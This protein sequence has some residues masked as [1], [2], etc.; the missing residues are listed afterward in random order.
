ML[1]SIRVQDPAASI[2][3]KSVLKEIESLQ[4][5]KDS[6]LDTDEVRLA[7]LRRPDSNAEQAIK[8]FKK[9]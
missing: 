8:V 6:I 3:S 5:I 7:A 2:R 4:D 1:P 9:D